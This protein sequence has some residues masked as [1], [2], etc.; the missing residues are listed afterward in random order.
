MRPSS[1][2]AFRSFKRLM[3]F[4]SVAQLVSVPP[5]QRWFTKK[6]PQRLASSATASWAWRLVPTNKTL[7][8]CADTSVTK[9]LASRNI[10]RSEE[11]TSELQSHHDLV[12]RLLLEKKKTH[13]T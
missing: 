9:R 8:P 11:H 12:C 10:L 7:L 13:D 5:S 4:C 1:V 3:D 2:M 6:A